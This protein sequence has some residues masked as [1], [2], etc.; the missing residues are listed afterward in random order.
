MFLLLEG[1]SP[2]QLEMCRKSHTLQKMRLEAEP[3]QFY[4]VHLLLDKPGIYLRE[5]KSTIE[6]ELGVEVTECNL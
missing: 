4:L 6:T 1:L 2:G 3:V 5:M